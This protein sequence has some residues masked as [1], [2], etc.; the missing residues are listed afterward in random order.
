MGWGRRNQHKTPLVDETCDGKITVTDPTHPLH[1]RTFRLVGMASPPRMGRCCTIEKLP[2]IYGQIPIASTN[3][4]K[5]SKRALTV[6]R[7]DAVGRLVQL[8]EQVMHEVNGRADDLQPGTVGAAHRSRASGDR[9][10]YRR[11]TR[12]GTR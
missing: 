2:G 10:P 11:D 7:G 1:G 5:E 8:Y 4:A 6:L 3:F 9:K 12:G